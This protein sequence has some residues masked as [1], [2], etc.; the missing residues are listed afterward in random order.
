VNTVERPMRERILQVA[1]ELFT[2]RGYDGTSLREIAEKLD[3]TKAAL[4]YHF[5]SKEALLLAL[6]IDWRSQVS[7]LVSWGHEQPFGADLQRVMLER[8]AGMLNGNQKVMR[9]LFENQPV[10]RALIANADAENQRNARSWIFDFIAAITPP[11]AD[12]VTRARVRAA[13]FAVVSGP[14]QPGTSA[15]D[16]EASLTVALELVG[17]PE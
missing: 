17:Q 15:A 5:K 14:M 13:A 2:E 12:A 8:L 6:V 10:I 3:V 7:E 1:L 9:L 11:D 16:L 4:Y